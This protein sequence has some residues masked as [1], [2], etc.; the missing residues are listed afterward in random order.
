MANLEME[1]VENERDY[2]LEALSQHVEPWK[3]VNRAFLRD[4]PAQALSGIGI[5][6][7]VE[8]RY[9]ITSNFYHGD[10]DARYDNNFNPRDEVH[11]RINERKLNYFFF[12]R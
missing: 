7:A 11:L 1:A 10:P 12:V 6:N 4:P 3:A 9:R 5:A 8:N 2:I